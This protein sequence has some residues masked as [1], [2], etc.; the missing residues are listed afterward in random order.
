VA[1]DSQRQLVK[2]YEVLVTITR[3]ATPRAAVM[4]MGLNRWRPEHDRSLCAI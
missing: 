1:S 3:H 4:E 2:C